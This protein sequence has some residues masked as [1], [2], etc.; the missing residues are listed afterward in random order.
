MVDYGVEKEASGLKVGVILVQEFEEF[1]AAHCAK[2]LND[3]TERGCQTQNIVMR[4]VPTIHDTV[5][6]T[7][8]FAEYTDV[9][10]V[11][12]IAPENQMNSM[13]SVMNGIY[14]LQIQWNMVVTIGSSD[15]L[16]ALLEMIMLQSEME[17][18]APKNV[19]RS[20]S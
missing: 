15:K 12:I 5:L 4:P 19:Q 17:M 14:Q 2:L 13:I 3:L 10:G 16:D 6:A 9:D 18:N 20:F 11:M 7:H 1:A 8:F